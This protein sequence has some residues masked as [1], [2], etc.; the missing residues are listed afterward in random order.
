MICEIGF[1][2]AVWPAPKNIIAG[3]TLRQSG[4]SQ[5]SFGALNLGSHVGDNIDNVKRNR[6]LLRDAMNL[7]SEPC[8]LKQKHSAKVVIEP[9]NE[10]VLCADASITRTVEKVCVVLTADCLPI[11]IT[12]KSGDIISAIH[13]GWRG[14]AGG[15]VENTINTMKSSPNELLVWLGP[16]I[17]QLAFEVGNDVRGIFLDLDI[18]NES[19]FKGN[20]RGR[21]Q[22]DL[23]AIVKLKLN[24]LGVRDIFGGDEC[25]FSDEKRLY[26][27][28]KD[29]ECGRMASI[30]YMQK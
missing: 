27:Y 24:R 4:F 11:L 14:L 28:R 5:G 18:N 10:I 15:I 30:I 19:C 12:S 29:N 2:E 21:W 17:S 6:R 25:T 16:A 7:P 13:A 20:K 3:T 22:A 26:S 9:S 23:Y 8:W 1:L